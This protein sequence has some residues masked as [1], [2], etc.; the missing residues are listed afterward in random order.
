MT[1]LEREASLAQLRELFLGTRDGR[2]RLVL[3]AGEA[4]IG[5]TALVEAFCAEQSARVQVLWGTCDAV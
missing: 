2:G 1:L 5:K 4:G 3:V